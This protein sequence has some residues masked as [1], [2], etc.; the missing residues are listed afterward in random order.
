MFSACVSYTNIDQ[1][2]KAG[3]LTVSYS[4][5]RYSLGRE[6]IRILLLSCNRMHNTSVDCNMKVDV[7]AGF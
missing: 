3:I 1:T 7:N 2:V 6:E 4:S 5:R